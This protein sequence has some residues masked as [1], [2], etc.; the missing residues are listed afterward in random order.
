MYQLVL[1]YA[2]DMLMIV[3]TNEAV[4]ATPEM[5]ETYVLKQLVL[6]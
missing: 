2:D 4:K 3:S 1:T 5:F 6:K